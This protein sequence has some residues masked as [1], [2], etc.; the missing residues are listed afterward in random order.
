MSKKVRGD[1]VPSFPF[2]IKPVV[3]LNTSI[4]NRNFLILINEIEKYLK[5]CFIKEV[6]YLR[7]ISFSKKRNECHL[8][9]YF[10]TLMTLL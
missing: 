8:R 3:S 7:W 2:F 4:V 9:A 6:L 5:V 1:H 10:E